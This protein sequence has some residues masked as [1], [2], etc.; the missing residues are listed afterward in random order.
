MNQ[1]LILHYHEIWLKGGNKKF[2]L[3]RL[4]KAIKE[5]LADLP[6]ASLEWVADRLLL[7][8]GS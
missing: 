2:F 1:V 6:V 3:S 7:T 4:I 5:T 8:S